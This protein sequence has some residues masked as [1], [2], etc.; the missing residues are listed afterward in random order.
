M[1]RKSRKKAFDAETM[2]YFENIAVSENINKTAVYVRLSKEDNGIEN[3]KALENQK[4]YI[5]NALSKFSDIN[6]IDIYSDN[7][8]TGVNFNRK[9]WELLI[10]DVKS[11]KINCIA[12]KDLSR[13]G[14]NSVEVGN[15]LEKVFPFLNVR[16]I[17]VNDNYDSAKDDYNKK[18]VENAFRN[19]M[20]EFYSR[21]ISKK[22]IAGIK[23]RRN[24]GYVTASNVGHGYKKSEDGKSILPDENAPIVERIF[25]WRRNGKSK[26]EIAN[27]LNTLAIPS[28]SQYLYLMGDGIKYK[29]YK[30][31]KWHTENVGNILSNRVYTGDL[32][33][34]KTYTRKFDGIKKHYADEEWFVVENFHKALVSK[35]DFEYIQGL[36]KKTKA[37][38]HK[39]KK[40]N[41][42]KGK[43]FCGKCGHKLKRRDPYTENTGFGCRSNEKYLKDLCG[44]YTSEKAIKELLRNMLKTYMNVFM[45]KIKIVEKL[46]NSKSFKEKELKRNKDILELRKKIKNTEFKIA[47]LYED[48]KAEILS[49]SDFEFIKAEYNKEY[50]EDM[51]RLNNLVTENNKSDDFNVL[52]R[53]LE[54]LYYDVSSFNDDEYVYSFV[55]KITVYSKNKIEIEFNFADT[56][57]KLEQFT[58]NGEVSE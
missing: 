36:K 46:R 47:E 32:I 55:K 21:D 35:E 45:S 41:Y 34:N 19:L 57:E 13:L 8:F 31:I 53:K 15:Y 50:S 29:R 1:A 48:Y 22:V 23:S 3:S 54:R 10:D 51:E 25:K 4:E 33:L 30:N 40:P 18:M 11:G 14:R 2:T 56:F 42:L 6:I 44:V 9:G 17:S 43:I 27:I 26:T 52:K 38:I 28:P 7:G 16:F 12:V 20:N 58:A 49:L 39:E 5:K 37:I 24:M